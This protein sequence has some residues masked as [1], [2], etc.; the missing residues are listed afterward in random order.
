MIKTEKIISM[1]NITK[2][3]S[4][5]CL[6]VFVC[7]GVSCNKN[8]SEEPPKVQTVSVELVKPDTLE[9]RGHIL[10]EGDAPIL[11][12]GFFY[13]SENSNPD[14][15]DNI[16]EVP[17]EL[18][19][20]S[21]L[22]GLQLNENYYF[23]SFAEN[24]FGVGRGNVRSIKVNTGETT[25]FPCQLPD[26]YS[27]IKSEGLIQLTSVLFGPHQSQVN[28]YAFVANADSLG[29][30]RLEFK[31]NPAV[32]IYPT[33]SLED[34]DNTSVYVEFNKEHQNN[35]VIQPGGEVYV[36]R[37]NQILQIVYC[38]LLY[39]EQGEEKLLE[40]QFYIEL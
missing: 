25:N 26:G 7:F 33:T 3:T 39:D 21:F 20:S 8:N 9:L 10:D 22:G 5:L 18:P 28:G 13:S 30:V 29:V 23:T 36:K 24:K 31:N 2:T 11:R 19:F 15:R 27:L 35:Y 4:V 16:I 1:K 17:L 12:K 32:G 14:S 38:G 34:W 6:F 37:L 40:G